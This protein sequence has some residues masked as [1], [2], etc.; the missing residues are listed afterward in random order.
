MSLTEWVPLDRISTEAREVHFGRT[1]LTLIAG[2]LWCIGWLA[3]KTLGTIWLAVAWSC[4][5]V[6]VGWV[7]ARRSAGG[8]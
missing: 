2:L 1:V 8:P 4:T 3:A 5:A 7:D 6:K